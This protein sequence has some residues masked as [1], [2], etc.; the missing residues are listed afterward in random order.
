MQLTAPVD[1]AAFAAAMTAFGPFEPSPMIAVGVSGGPDSLALV[2]LLN[3]WARSRGGSVLALTVDHGLRRAAADEARQ[4]GDWLAG[5]GIAHEILTWAGAKSGSG[6]QASARRARYSLLARACG[7]RG[8]LHLA[9][10]HHADDQA[11]TV[12][13]RRERGSGAEGLAGMTASRS[14]G[15]VRLIRPLLAWPKDA[16]I[17]TCAALGQPFIEDPSNRSPAY[18]RSALRQRLAADPAMR[19]SLLK[20]AADAGEMRAQLGETVAS[21]LGRVATLGPDGVG[22][23]DRSGLT[24]APPEL[25]CA[26]LA[27]M[28]RTVGGG[29]FAPTGDAL[30]RLDQ[31]IRTA[32]FSGASLAGC[33]I[34]PWRGALL[35]CREAV[36]AAP[37]I[38]LDTAAPC[39]WDDRFEFV[40]AGR[41]PDLTVG[42][43]GA[44]GWA[45]L[46]RASKATL[47]AVAGRSLPALRQDQ[48][49]VA[50]PVLGLPPDGSLPVKQRL[51]PLWPLASETFTVVSA[52]ADIMSGRGRRNRRVQTSR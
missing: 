37:P 23:L 8:I 25:R 2:L 29:A 49:V 26:A 35:V 10:A 17:A 3:D 5:R 28:L 9:I 30:T 44:K 34:R 38:P 39:R 43:L 52:G 18:A 20:I 32:D 22:L 33:H 27:A 15:L 41:S 14:L 19:A 47:P 42:A 24:S 31:A 51:L 36:R 40:V 45:G 12:L 6:I 7:D 4:V 1:P 48:E 46:R 21:L 11:E 13:F 16:L 50:I